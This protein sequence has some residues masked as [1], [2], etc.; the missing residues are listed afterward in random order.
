MKTRIQKI[1]IIAA[2]L[3]FVGSG[4]SF[5][6]EW[7]DRDYNPPGKLSVIIRSK[8]SHLAGSTRILD[9]I[10]RSPRDMFTKKSEAIGIMMATVGARHP[11]EM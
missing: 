10:L 6:H 5:A 7:N 8:R 9:R 4:A 2:T 1:I 3:I 11:A